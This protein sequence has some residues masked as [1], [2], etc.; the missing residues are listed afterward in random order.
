M[1]VSLM[2]ARHLQQ[3]VGEI[4][5]LIK[6]ATSFYFRAKN[7]IDRILVG[8][9]VLINMAESIN[10]ENVIVLTLPDF[11]LQRTNGV[12]QGDIIG[13][14]V[15]IAVNSIDAHNNA[16]KMPTNKQIIPNHPETTYI[17]S[18]LN[19]YFPNNYPLS[20]SVEL[21]SHTGSPVGT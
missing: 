17:T 2:R 15:G 16:H 6:K 8:D 12:A 10:A 14:V 1:G 9:L 5:E 19:Q 21:K 7:A 11:T 18:A 4:M 3:K 20:R 13:V